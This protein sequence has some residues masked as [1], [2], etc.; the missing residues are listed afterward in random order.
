MGIYL[1]QVTTTLHPSTLK[2]RVQRTAH[3]ARSAVR[4]NPNIPISHEGGMLCQ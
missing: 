2:A 1:T 3:G 4:D